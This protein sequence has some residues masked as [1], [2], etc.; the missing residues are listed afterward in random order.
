[1]QHEPRTVY[2]LQGVYKGT[3][4]SMCVFIIGAGWHMIL[5]LVVRG[6]RANEIFFWYTFVWYWVWIPLAI[7]HFARVTR[8]INTVEEDMVEVGEE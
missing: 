7:Y 2:D 6:E 3:V 4:I 1:M 5:P 8:I